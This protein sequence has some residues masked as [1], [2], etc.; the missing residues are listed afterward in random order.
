MQ[1]Q[2]QR[3]SVNL[4]GPVAQLE[5]KIGRVFQPG[6]DAELG[7]HKCRVDLTQSKWRCETRIRSAESTSM[8]L[9]ALTGYATGL[10]VYGHAMFMSGKLAGFRTAIRE[11]VTKA[12]TRHI[13]FWESLPLRPDPGDKVEMIVGCDKRLTTCVSRFANAVNFQGMPHMPSDQ[14]LVRAVD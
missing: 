8:E 10:F 9:P 2:G 14:L 7:D 3:F 12:D 4:E 13:G 11:D 5:K 1:R 6:C